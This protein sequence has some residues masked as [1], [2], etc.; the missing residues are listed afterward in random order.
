M[1]IFNEQEK[2]PQRSLISLFSPANGRY[3]VFK[4]KLKKVLKLFQ[5][6]ENFSNI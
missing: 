4:Q 2:L 6:S 5:K 3:L 1:K